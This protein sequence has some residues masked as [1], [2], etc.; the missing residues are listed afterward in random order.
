MTKAIPWELLWRCHSYTSFFFSVALCSASISTSIPLSR[1]ASKE[2]AGAV[3]SLR[4]EWRNIK[5]CSYFTQLGPQHKKEICLCA[6][7]F[8]RRLPVCCKGLLWLCNYSHLNN[9]LLHGCL[10]LVPRQFNHY[11]FSCRELAILPVIWNMGHV[12]WRRCKRASPEL[13]GKYTFTI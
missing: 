4:H 13:A 11:A 8:Q 9:D 2:Q 1:P 12:V 7:S 3:N 5:I 6:S 10:L